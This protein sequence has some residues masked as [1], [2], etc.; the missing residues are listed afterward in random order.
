MQ[1]IKKGIFLNKCNYEGSCTLM[2]NFEFSFLVSEGVIKIYLCETHA[3]MF[4]NDL[5]KNFVPKGVK[6]VF[7]NSKKV[8]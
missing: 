6:S 1:I 2:A 8:L 5:M 7:I 3:E 4:K